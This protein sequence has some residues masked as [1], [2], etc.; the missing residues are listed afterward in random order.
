MDEI[1]IENT[2]SNQKNPEGVI[3]IKPSL[4]VL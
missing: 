3:L 1:S 2:F 4:G